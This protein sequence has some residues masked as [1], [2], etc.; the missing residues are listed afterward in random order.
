M[1]MLKS[2]VHTIVPRGYSDAGA[3]VV[4]VF[5][6]DY[7]DKVGSA[8]GDGVSR[9]AVLSQEIVDKPLSSFSGMEFMSRNLRDIQEAASAK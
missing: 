7:S 9:F 3:R 2:K 8:L 6:V 4:T 5:T 1:I